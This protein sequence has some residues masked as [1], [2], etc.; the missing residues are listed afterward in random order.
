MHVSPELLEVEARGVKGNLSYIVKI[1]LKNESRK[2]SY[3]LR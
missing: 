3:V 2:K 1:Y